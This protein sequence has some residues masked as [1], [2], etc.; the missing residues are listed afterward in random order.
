MTG[1]TPNVRMLSILENLWKT[2][3]KVRLKKD[4]KLFVLKYVHNSLT[5]VR[6]KFKENS[7]M[8]IEKDITQKNCHQERQMQEKKEFEKFAIYQRQ[9]MDGWVDE[10]YDK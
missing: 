3:T 7:Q 2:C 10:G 4:P 5:W 8:K 6:L 1:I 9:W